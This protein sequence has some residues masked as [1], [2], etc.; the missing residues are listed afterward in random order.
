MVNLNS[1]IKPRVWLNDSLDVVKPVAVC[2]C[3]MHILHSSLCK[4][5]ICTKY[6]DEVQYLP[7]YEIY[8]LLNSTNFC[9]MSIQFIPETVILKNPT[10]ILHAIYNFQSRLPKFPKKNTNTFNLLITVW[11]M[12]EPILQGLKLTTRYRYKLCSVDL[13]Q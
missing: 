10:L 11:L 8:N 5:S 6:L 3:S 2:F 12:V 1:Q 9:L 4:C 7:K 13:R